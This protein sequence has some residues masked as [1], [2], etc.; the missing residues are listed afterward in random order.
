MKKKSL[1]VSRPRA[2]EGYPRA[3]LVSSPRASRVAPSSSLAR[4]EVR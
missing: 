2:L 3:R 1:D 4:V